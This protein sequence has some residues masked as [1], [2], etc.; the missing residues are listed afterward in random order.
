[1]TLPTYI[2]LNQ[3]RKKINIEHS[4]HQVSL[5]RGRQACLCYMYGDNVCIILHVKLVNWSVKMHFIIRA[6]KD[7]EKCLDLSFTKVA[8]AILHNNIR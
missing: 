7:I 6:D 2:Q 8:T 4:K 5:G 1:M 3:V